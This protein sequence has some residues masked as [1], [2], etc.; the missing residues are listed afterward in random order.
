[1]LIW[2]HTV[3]R[4]LPYW[5]FIGETHSLPQLRWFCNTF[6]N[7][8]NQQRL[9]PNL[10]TYQA[11]TKGRG[12]T[13]LRLP[14]FLKSSEQSLKTTKR[15]EKRY[16][17]SL[18]IVDRLTMTA[19][20]LNQGGSTRWFNPAAAIRVESRKPTG[21]I[22]PTIDIEFTKPVPPAIRELFLSVT[23]I[24]SVRPAFLMAIPSQTNCSSGGIPWTY[25]PRWIGVD[26]NTDALGPAAHF[27]LNCGPTYVF[28]RGPPS[29]LF[30][31]EPKENLQYDLVGYV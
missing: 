21:F 14:M 4:W 12:A 5:V 16:N 10:K 1:M 31:L 7:Q 13:L 24:E 27:E 18:V 19:T 6:L 20:A 17:L 15:K 29:P 23:R 26:I 22:L 3:I 11:K 8:A 25:S 28:T 9:L 2:K 30:A